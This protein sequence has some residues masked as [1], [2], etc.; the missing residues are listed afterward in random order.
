MN[1]MGN[2]PPSAM[3]KVVAVEP[4]MRD[5]ADRVLCTLHSALSAAD[6]IDNK[7]FA[8]RPV[9]CGQTQSDIESG[10]DMETILNRL[11]SASSKLESVLVNIS[12]K[13]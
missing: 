1:Q 2:V 4:S 5:I 9:N 11:M 12:D 7:L 6:S 3:N 13:L 8:P 10:V